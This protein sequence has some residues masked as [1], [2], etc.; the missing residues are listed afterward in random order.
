MIR[1]RVPAFLSGQNKPV[2]S[3]KRARQASRFPN[4]I[5]L[6]LL[7]SFLFEAR[8]CS[9]MRTWSLIQ[10]QQRN[11]RT[12]ETICKQIYPKAAPPPLEGLPSGIQRD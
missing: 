2:L 1:P 9:F 6:N 8:L 4:I 10:G 5:S 3:A 12:A 7:A 11:Q